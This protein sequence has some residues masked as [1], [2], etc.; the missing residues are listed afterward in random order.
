M[1]Q[2]RA[3]KRAERGWEAPR[4]CL[5]AA[6]GAQQARSGAGRVGMLLERLVQGKR[7]ARTQL[8]V[9]VEEQ[10][11]SPAR[12]AQQLGVV[13]RLSA[14]LRE[15]HHAVHSRVIAGGARGS[16]AR[17][18]V[19]HDHLRGE[20]QRSALGGDR[21]QAAQQQ[22]ALAGVDD[23]VGQLDL[24]LA[25][26]ARGVLGGGLV[27]ALA[28]RRGHDVRLLCLPMRVHV[29]DPSAYTPPYDHA[30]CSA[31]AHAGAEVSLYTSRFAYGRAQPADSYARRELFY[32]GA[33]FAAGSPVRRACK[34]LEH[35]PDMLLYRRAARD[36]DVVHFQWLAVQHLDGRLL[37]SRH[38]RGE[39]RRPL[40]LTAHDVLPREP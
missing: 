22:L 13:E 39:R 32:R 4:A 17:V 6:V 21:V 38:A 20:R 16:V 18:V 40:V 3:C 5:R 7:R 24:L 29:V 28:L 10:R 8:G 2:Q 23:A 12:A 31:L 26:I 34:L 1:Q 11:I 33:R 9:L 30:L 25:A 36:A 15:R 37:P 19:E 35:V 14:P 27:V